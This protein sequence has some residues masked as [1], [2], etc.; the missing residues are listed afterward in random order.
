M[1]AK[2]VKARINRILQSTIKYQLARFDP[3][4]YTFRDDLQA[5]LE[6]H[7]NLITGEVLEIGSGMWMWP[8]QRFSSQ[9]HFRTLDREM[10]DGTDIVGDV[11]QLDEV[12]PPESLDAVL[13][14]ETLEHVTDPRRALEQI[15]AALKP[16]ATLL[17]SAPFRY[18]LHGEN[19]G[20]FWRFTRQG[21]G[22]LLTDFRDVRIEWLG[23]E[24]DPHHYLVSGRK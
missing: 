4:E 21:W 24:L 14:L 18:E 7:A 1:D 8:K 19:Y 23:D 6:R 2:F 22:L 5:F 3:T 12:V 11:L 9:S 15:H 17:A 16:G 13:C 10:Y 20:D